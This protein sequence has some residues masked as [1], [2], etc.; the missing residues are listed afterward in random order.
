MSGRKRSHCFFL[1][2]NHVEWSK[3]S[4]GEWLLAAELASEFAIGEE[5]YHPALNPDTGLP[6]SDPVGRHHHIY[7]K[8]IEGY[9]YEEVQEIISEFLGG[10]VYS[11]NLQVCKSPKAVLIYLSKDD[12]CPMLFN[13]RVSQLSLY[14]RAWHHA[15]TT[16]K[17]ITTVT[18]NDP[19]IVASGLNARFCLGI[20]E[21][22]LNDLRSGIIA[23]KVYF[24]PNRS[25]KFINDILQSLDSG[26]HTYVHGLPGL[27]KTEVVDYFLQG[28]RFWKA[29]EPSNFIFGTIN[30]SYDYVW[31]EDYDHDK[32]RPNLI[33]LLSL[34]D[35][36]E[37]TISKKGVDDRTILLHAQFIFT[38]NF[39][40][41]T[42]YDM[43]RRRVTYID[44]THKT[45]EC[46]GCMPAYIPPQTIPDNQLGLFDLEDEQIMI[47]L[48]NSME[49]PVNDI[50]DE[51]A[52]DVSRFMETGLDNIM[53]D[54]EIEAFFEA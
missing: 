41:P 20:I 33:N 32:Y 6:S 25:C 49:E 17:T 38:S 54:E 30:E 15:R 52:G 31:F 13:V 10:E 21:E 42:N 48:M 36:K 29:G 9:R 47:D 39:M 19:F 37:T 3:S 50:S 40:I 8:F 1:T 4:F 14:A 26:A 22:H 35:H 16:Y 51:N 34:M 5:E 46:T 7:I 12:K 53:T 28:K 23:D 44:V 45:F 27:G 24:H 2:I 11:F 43:F 18:K